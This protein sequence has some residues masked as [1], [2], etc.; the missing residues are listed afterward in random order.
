[1]TGPLMGTRYGMLDFHPL[2]AVGWLGI[3][4]APVHPIHPNVATAFVTSAGL[5]IWFFSGM[6]GFAISVS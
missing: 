6:V 1:M 5:I 4:L 3:V 2:I